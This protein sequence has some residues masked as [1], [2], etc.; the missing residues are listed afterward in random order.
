MITK[1]FRIENIPALLW[2]EPSNPLF[3]AVHG[4]MSS[5]DDTVIAI[6]AQ[7]AL[8]KGYS[9]LS[10]DLPGHGDRH[11]QDPVFSIQS[12]VK[13][14]ETIYEHAQSLGTPVGVFGCS[15]GAYL[16]LLAYADQPMERSLFLSPVL[17]MERILRNMMQ[18]FGISEEQLKAEKIIETP[19]GQTL[20]WDD[21]LYVL[22]NPVGEWN[23][24]A[25]ILYGAKDT[26]CEWDPL[27]DF[28]ARNVCTL[29]VME[30]GEH[31]FQTD[32][33]LEHYRQWL[34]KHV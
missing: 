20:Y 31:F 6:F 29:D 15:L 13:D 7:M 1:R 28:V 9:V 30:S 27:Q 18:E 21:Y 8:Q 23:K 10:F 25:M 19:I 4:N 32:E 3:I 22:L 17:N 16:S 33:Q 26:L 14:L 12:C 24:D 5:K 11:A 34:E 2:G